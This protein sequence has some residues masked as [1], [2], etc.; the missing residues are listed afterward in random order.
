MAKVIPG[1]EEY[2][3]TIRYYDA[4]IKKHGVNLQVG[5]K[6]TVEG[7]TSQSY[8][9]IL[10][11]TGV[12]PRKINIP[13]ENHKKALT[14]AEV[15]YQNKHV[16]KSVAIIGA[17][18]IGF[19]MAEYLAHGKDQPSLDVPTYM[20]EWGVD[21]K[22]TNPGAGASP[23]PEPSPREIHLLKRS[24]G[25][26]GKG[27]GKT[28]GW[29]HRASLK[30]KNVNMIANVTYNKIDDE[31]LHITKGDE[32]ILLPVDNVVICAGQEPLRAMYEELKAAGMNVHLIGGADDAAGL[33]AKRAIKQ[34]SELAATL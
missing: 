24:G 30:M 3:E 20:K 8:D 16:G 22:Y 29:I 28:T 9:E 4:M 15:L 17:G 33:D 31:G 7:L 2:Q 1:K 32:S 21:M 19:D 13:G 34:A 18:G 26:H 25:K 10:L 27:L 11:C 14:Y 6:Q 5:F 12:T 23:Q